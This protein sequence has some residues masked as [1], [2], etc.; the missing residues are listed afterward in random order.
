MQVDPIKP[1]LKAPGTKRLKLKYDEPLS[2]VA[3]KVN[4]RRYNLAGD[5]LVEVT[6]QLFLT[7]IEVS[8]ANAAEGAAA[9]A[10]AAGEGARGC[11]AKNHE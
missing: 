7:D 3:L 10:A 11:P 1:T 5:C 9:S 6:K 2:N 4:L 8:A